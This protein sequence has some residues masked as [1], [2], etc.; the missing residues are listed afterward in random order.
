MFQAD[1]RLTRL[2]GDDEDSETA[3]L[4][5]SYSPLNSAT[6]VSRRRPVLASV[7]VLGCVAGALAYS[8]YAKNA[9]S[10]RSSK[11]LSKTA[12]I[13]LADL[14]PRAPVREAT[15]CYNVPADWKDLDGQTCA[16]YSLRSFCSPY[17]EAGTGWSPTWGE[18]SRYAVGGKD[19][20]Q[21]CCACGGGS[22]PP[23]T[24]APPTCAAGYTLSHFGWWDNWSKLVAP[25]GK[26][27]EASF[28]SSAACAVICGKTAGCS[29]YTSFDSQVCWLYQYRGNIVENAKSVACVL[30][31]VSTATSTTTGTSTTGVKPR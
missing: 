20:P 28:M 5:E 19:A 13:S 16:D 6:P 1:G 3:A 29:A 14:P 27:S 17:G 24:P 18:L 31:G 7:V 21:A 12:A 23:T 25:F 9:T 22:T 11:A 15:A 10:L 30:S 26:Q 4:N 8:T 2:Q